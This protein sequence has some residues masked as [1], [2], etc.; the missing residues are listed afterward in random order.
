MKKKLLAENSIK[1]NYLNNSLSKKFSKKY[2]KILK[3]LH[4]DLS[5]PKKTLSVLNESYNFNFK[6]KDLYKFKKY[7]SVILIGMGGSILGSEAI[8]EFL[9]HKIR[10]KFYFFDNID[11]QMVLDLKK[12]ENLKKTL[13]IVISK[14]GDTIETLAN[15][16]N[17]RILKKNS[18]NIIII[19]EKKSFLHNLSK[20]L[21]LFFVEHNKFIGGR[22][23]VLSEVGMIPAY[24]MG[25]NFKRLR[26]D[27]G[28]HTLKEKETFLKESCIKMANIFSQK[29]Y[30]NL[31]F[32]NYSPKLEK[33]LFWCQQLL[34]ESLGKKGK[35]LL[36]IISNAPKDHHSLLQLYLDG[37]KDKLICIFNYEEKYNEKNKIRRLKKKGIKYLNNKTLN[38]I[39]FAQKE[40]L[41]KALNNNNIPFREFNIKIAEEET[42]SELFSYFILETIIIGKLLGLNPFNQPA[43]EQV[44]NLTKK[45][46]N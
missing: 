46:L 20:E 38:S 17:L 6:L 31:I 37:P 15:L 43:V 36:P 22:F 45:L 5:N 12:N 10:K 8:Y 26:M 3:D 4:K 25:I 21:K 19:S 18:K 30:R 16:Y 34:A 23:S 7:N 29:R 13:F 39:K 28:A 9:K 42:L 24:L 44:K 14:S 41:K 1:K 35:G 40:A 32:L 2:K 33:F 27:L 11:Q